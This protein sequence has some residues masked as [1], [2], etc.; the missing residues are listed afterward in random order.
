M[1]WNKWF[2]NTFWCSFFSIRVCIIFNLKIGALVFIYMQ[3]LD[4]S[5][6]FHLQYYATKIIPQSTAPPLAR[7]E[8]RKQKRRG[9]H[10]FSFHFHRNTP[11]QLPLDGFLSPNKKKKSLFRCRLWE[12]IIVEIVQVCKI[13][14]WLLLK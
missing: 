9:G 2:L 5:L 6:E 10:I 11:T 3:I 14:Q 4:F 1:V 7:T 8:R 13:S 12:E